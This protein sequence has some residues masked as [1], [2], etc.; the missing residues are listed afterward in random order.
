MVMAVALD[1][2][3]K[4]IFRLEGG[5]LAGLSVRVLSTCLANARGLGSFRIDIGASNL[6]R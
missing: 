3:G 4:G 6:E 5:T 1:R 2:V